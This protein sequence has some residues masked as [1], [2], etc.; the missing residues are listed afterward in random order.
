M[1]SLIRK[2]NEKPTMQVCTRLKL[3]NLSL[4]QNNKHQ[5]SFKKKQMNTY[6]NRKNK[7]NI[8]RTDT[9]ETD[10]MK[11]IAVNGYKTQ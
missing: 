7:T 8:D 1:N 5:K 10:K 11:T 2:L 6:T 4:H 3:I 9:S